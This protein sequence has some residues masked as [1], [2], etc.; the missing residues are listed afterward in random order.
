[1]ISF[2][3]EIHNWSLSLHNE[4]TI[5]GYIHNHVKPD[6]YHDGDY[7]KVKLKYKPSEY[8]DYF[9]AKTLAGFIYKLPKEKELK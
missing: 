9:V 2:E 7:I 5:E 3:G 1:M 4:P 6:L 8:K